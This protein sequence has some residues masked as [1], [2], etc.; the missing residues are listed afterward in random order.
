MKINYDF[1]SNELKFDGLDFNNEIKFFYISSLLN[2]FKLNIYEN[3]IKALLKKFDI[4][5]VHM[6]LF[7]YS[8]GFYLINK[9]GMKN[10]WLTIET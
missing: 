9:I 5:T 10:K 7:E 3:A 2:R 6:Y 8:F 4:Q 1:H